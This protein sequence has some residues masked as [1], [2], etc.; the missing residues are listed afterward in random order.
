MAK[1]QKTTKKSKVND[2]AV[3]AARINATFNNIIISLTNNQ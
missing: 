2:E 1:T 3:G